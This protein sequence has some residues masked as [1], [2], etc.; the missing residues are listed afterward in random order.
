MAFWNA[1]VENPEH[2]KLAVEAAQKM[3]RTI[4][5]VND[6]ISAQGT[7]SFDLRIGIG[8]ATGECV[9]GNMGS[10]QRFDYTVLGDV[11]NLASRLEGQTKGYGITTVLC[12]NTAAAV[13]G[14]ANG[15]R[16]TSSTPAQYSQR[17]MLALTK[18]KDLIC[19]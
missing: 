1:P 9:V 12:K 8:V 2:A 13:T 5:K 17:Y 6:T 7:V 18:L 4:Y 15:P 19:C 10:K 3:M 11:V 14:P 16:P